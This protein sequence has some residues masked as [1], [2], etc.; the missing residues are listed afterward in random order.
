[1]LINYNYQVI[2]GRSLVK[3][4]PSEEPLGHT[5]QLFMQL[6][7]ISCCMIMVVSSAVFPLP[8]P[9][10]ISTTI[11]AVAGA[12]GAFAVYPIDY[13]KTQMQSSQGSQYTD[14]F[15]AARKIVS[16]GSVRA[17]YRG[18]GTQVAGVAPE[19]TVKLL[20]NDAVRNALTASL[21]CLPLWAEVVAGS[22]AGA[23]QVLVTNPL[24]V[25]KVGL[26][27]QT[28]LSAE[29][30][31]RELGVGGLWNGATACVVRDASFSAI[32]FPCYSHAKD[33]LTFDGTA[34]GPAGLF[35]AGVL[36]AV[37]AAY[38]TTPADVVK[39]RLQQ[40]GGNALRVAVA[41]DA[42]GLAC[43]PA[44]VAATEL[45]EE[46]GRGVLFSGG[47]ER[48]LRSAPQFGVTLALFDVL[49]RLCEDFGWLPPMA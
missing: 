1:M 40:R 43:I 17:L 13:I 33:M 45:I 21:G 4:K 7:L 8:P 27:T 26:Q 28:D 12:V 31:I 9:F 18:C 14:G 29:Q 10:V 22:T 25:V 37:P 46:E 34:A 23:C 38:L 36:A 49:K 2:K 5:S 20:V 6:E 19:K 32:L 44:Y 47:I 35:I 41:K 15:D 11:G 39:T 3:N 42:R 30:L 48:V 24:E 16:K